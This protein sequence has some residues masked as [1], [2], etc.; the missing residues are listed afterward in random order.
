MVS[1]KRERRYNQVIIIFH[2][3]CLI[4]FHFGIKYT[5]GFIHYTVACLLQAT[6]KTFAFVFIN[7]Q[8]M[9]LKHFGIVCYFIRFIIIIIIIMVIFFGALVWRCRLKCA[10]TSSKN[11]QNE[12][13]KRKLNLGLSKCLSRKIFQ[14]FCS[15][16]EMRSLCFS[17][18]YIGSNCKLK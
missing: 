3:D 17:V 9:T 8:W 14:T 15:T 12:W 4:V 2:E 13:H 6:T 5:P 1:L 7:K 16:F 10:Q 11:Q 18:N